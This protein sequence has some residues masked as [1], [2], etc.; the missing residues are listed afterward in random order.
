MTQ[1]DDGPVSPD[2]FFFDGVMYR[3]RKPLAWRL[4]NHLWHARS[5]RASV[6]SLAI[7]VW[8][9]AEHDISY[10]AVATLRRDANRFFVQNCLP[11]RMKVG[12]DVA[13]LIDDRTE[14]GSLNG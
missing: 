7:G 8:G 5:R 9:D 13:M 14:K 2:G 11:F 3:L 12:Q 4:I 1:L 10:L 6:D